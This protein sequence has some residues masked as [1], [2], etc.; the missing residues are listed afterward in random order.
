[1]LPE[2]SAQLLSLASDH[3]KTWLV[4]NEKF[5]EWYKLLILDDSDIK[6]ADMECVISNDP[7]TFYK[8]ALRLLTTSISHSIPTDNMS[9]PEMIDTTVIVKFLES[10]WEKK[11]RG[12][13]RRGGQSWLAEMVS[14]LLVTGWYDVLTYAD[15]IDGC[16]A[17]VRNPAECYPM[18]STDWDGG[19]QSHFHI[20]NLNYDLA[21]SRCTHH[22]W[23]PLAIKRNRY[24]MLTV[25]DYWCMDFG[26]VYNTV[27]MDNQIVKPLTLHPQF[28][29]I[30]I[31]SGIASGM[32]DKG[33]IMP[34]DIDWSARVGES[35]IADNASIY[36]NYN[37]MLSFVQQI[38]RDVAQPK[39]KER[40]ESDTPILNPDTMFKRGAIFRMGVNEDVEPVSTPPLPVELSLHGR[41]LEG[42][43]QR[44]SFPWSMYGSLS[45]SLTAYSMSQ[46]TAAAQEILAD[47]ADAIKYILSEVDNTWIAQMRTGRLRIDGFM[48]SPLYPLFLRAKVDVAVSVPGDFMQRATLSRM[49]SPD[50]RFSTRT[51]MELMW[52]EIKDPELEMAST[53]ADMALQHPVAISINLISAWRQQAAILREVG[54]IDTANLFDRAATMIESQLGPIVRQPSEQLPRRELAMAEESRQSTALIGS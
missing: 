39:M 23:S 47:Y 44:G 48:I 2:T 4:R 36:T 19:L 7:K 24:S 52:N 45:T 22:G 6:Q 40:S 53:R 54:D 50:F 3:K 5:K 31:L 8:K 35:I 42:M 33:S 28:D 41:D 46:V 32:P 37:K 11:A 14:F 10:Q 38:I 13:R 27:M 43:I 26:Q 16:V 9:Q 51:V 12:S 18:F 20:Y 30:P 29:E 15:E 17:A 34:Y 21:M 49:L 25:H 1:M